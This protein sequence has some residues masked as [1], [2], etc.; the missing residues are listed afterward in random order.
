MTHSFGAVVFR[1]LL[2]QVWTGDGAATW[3]VLGQEVGGRVAK[4]MEL[5]GGGHHP[6]SWEVNAGESAFSLFPWLLHL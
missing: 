5:Q 2:S 1:D 3:Q 6:W 4:E